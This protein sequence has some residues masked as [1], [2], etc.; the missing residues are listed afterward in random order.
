M[1]L[2]SAPAAYLLAAYV[3]VARWHR[4]P[5]L[6]NTVIHENGRLTLLGSVLYFDHFVACVPMILVFALCCAGGVALT[7][8]VADGIAA[9]RAG[10]A[11][12]LLLGIA[13]L[14][15]LG[16][17]VAS[18]L[19][20]GRQRT[21][22][23][24]LQ[25]IERDGVMSK[26]GNWN[27]LQLSN[28]PIALGTIGFGSALRVVGVGTRGGSLWAGGLACVAGAVLILVTLSAAT[29]FTWRAFCNP[30]WL[31]HSIREVATFP[32]TG[33]PI[34]LASIVLTESVLSGATLWVVQPDWLSLLLIALGL[35]IVAVELALLSGADVLAM[36]QQPSFA[37]T[38]LSIPYLLA[39]HVFEHVLDFVLT[40]LLA[41]GL[42]AL[43]LWFALPASA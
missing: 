8:R 2:L 13:A 15:I 26:G 42:Y 10:F 9:S 40:A 23:Y 19:T 7:G 5:W 30:R 34:A 1:L 39:A 32:V 35:L 21:I 4:T 17:F 41:G 11:A 6:L 38:G 12:V 37:A 14:L 3:Y 25:R 28:I 20:V 31:A 43:L 24:A 36:A 16:A 18:V 29:A 33:I 22:D 27:Q